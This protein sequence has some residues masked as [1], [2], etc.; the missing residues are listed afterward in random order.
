[1][2]ICVSVEHFNPKSFI[3]ANEMSADD[4]MET[5]RYLDENDTAFLEMLQEPWFL[6][7][8]L[9]DWFSLRN[10]SYLFRDLSGLIN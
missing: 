4:L 10:Q 9:P 2:N 1:M 8:R 5:I 6:D 3:N 7:N